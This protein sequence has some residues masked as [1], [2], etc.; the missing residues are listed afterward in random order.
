MNVEY[1]NSGGYVSTARLLDNCGG[2][3]LPFMPEKATV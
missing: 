1:L 2:V 3:S